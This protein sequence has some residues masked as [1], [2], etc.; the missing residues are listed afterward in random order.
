MSLSA[1]INGEAQTLVKM[2]SLEDLWELGDG[3]IE[4]MSGLVGEFLEDA[5]EQ[6]EAI[7][8]AIGSGDAVGM[9]N[10]G[11]ALKGS[12]ANLGAGRVSDLCAT[13]QTKGDEGELDGAEELLGLLKEAMGSTREIL[14]DFLAERSGS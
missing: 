9:R 6:I 13:F 11:H 1:G 4:F 12:S 7:G 2:Q 14:E 8:V 10:A 5:A 3:D